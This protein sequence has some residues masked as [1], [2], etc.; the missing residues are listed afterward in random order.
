MSA[1]EA[2]TS[3]HSPCQHPPPPPAHFLSVREISG[4]ESETRILSSLEG[5]QGPEAWAG[6]ELAGFLLSGVGLGLRGGWG[7]A[8][9]ERTL[10]V[11][12]TPSFYRLTDL[13]R[14]TRRDI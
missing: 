14:W 9:L 1:S 2:A 10:S 8:L 5:V 6:G 7:G 12:F 13:A 11:P 3:K 4:I